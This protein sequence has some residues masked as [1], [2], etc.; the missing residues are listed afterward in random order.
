[1]TESQK[2][3][4]ANCGSELGATAETFEIVCGVCGT[5]QSIERHDG[6]SEVVEV[7]PAPHR[8]VDVFRYLVR[9][10][11]EMLVWRWNWKAALFSG[12]LRSLIYLFTHLK[13]GC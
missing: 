3:T 4:C 5:R 12:I 7:S 1:M 9:H 10:P 2:L 6:V 11:I 8:V 13:E